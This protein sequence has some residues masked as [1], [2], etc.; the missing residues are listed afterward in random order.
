MNAPL[1][2]F[3]IKAEGATITASV[4]LHQSLGIHLGSKQF[5]LKDLQENQPFKMFFRSA[6]VLL[7]V[8]LVVCVVPYWCEAQREAMNLA[9]SHTDRNG[10]DRPV[11]RLHGS[12]NANGAGSRRTHHVNTQVGV[13]TT[14]YRSRNGRHSVGVGA[15]RGQGFGRWNGQRYQSRPSY[16]AGVGYRFRF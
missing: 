6:S 12:V 7:L 8:A 13:G 11:G 1:C 9:S 4:T 15:T 2:L 5:T 3:I 14:V 16:S 10:R